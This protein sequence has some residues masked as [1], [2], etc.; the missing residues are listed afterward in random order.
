[1][2]KFYQRTLWGL[3]KAIITVCAFITGCFIFYYE[4]T[5]PE[6]RL[7]CIVKAKTDRAAS[8]CNGLFKK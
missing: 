5:V 3:V 7:K 2:D 4:L 8:V 1:M 6:N